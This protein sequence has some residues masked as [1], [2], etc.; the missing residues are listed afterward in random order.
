M[1]M[2]LIMSQRSKV[3]S[4]QTNTNTYTYTHT[5]KNTNVQ[6]HPS[7]VIPVLKKKRDNKCQGFTQVDHLPQRITYIL[8]C[9]S[10]R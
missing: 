7:S 9:N 10:K 2:I 1:M 8:T 5:K 4:S 3:F 6:C